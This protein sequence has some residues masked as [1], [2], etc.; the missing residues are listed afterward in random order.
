MSV[1]AGNFV[2]A[3]AAELAVE[4]VA[5]PAVVAA[6]ATPVASA[7]F[8]AAP[9]W[10][11]MANCRNQIRQVAYRRVSDA[12]PASSPLCESA[13]LAT[14]VCSSP[15]MASPCNSPAATGSCST[16]PNVAVTDYCKVATA[17][18]PYPVSVAGAGLA[19]GREN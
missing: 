15:A 6:A 9:G 5:G 19:V 12:S 16:A 18:S 4:P 3:A 10:S 11:S 17:C 7:P 13:K 2:A 14:T 8:V 1:A